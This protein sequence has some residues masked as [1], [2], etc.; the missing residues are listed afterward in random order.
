MAHESPA[1]VPKVLVLNYEYPPLGGG[2]ANATAE[3]LRRLS[4]RLDAACS[5]V[6]SS[7][8]EARVESL[9]AS[10]C[11]HFL[12]IHKDENLH[13]QSNRELLTYSWKA[14]WYARRLSRRER[15]DVAHA[16]FGIPCGFIAMLLGVPYIVS[17]RGSDVPGYS[18]RYALADRLIFRRLSR[19]VW[20]R[21]AAV[22]ANSRGLRELA[23]RT[24]KHQPISVIP[25]GVDTTVFRPAGAG[26][27]DEADT[28]RLLYV[29]RLI[30]R[31]GV[32]GLLRALGG[33]GNVA[34]TVAGDGPERERLGR[35]AGEYGVSVRFPGNVAHAELP[36]LY[37]EHDAFVLPSR[38]EGMSN[39]VLEAMASGLP[40][41]VT[42]VGGTAELVDGN[43]VVVPVDDEAALREAVVGLRDDR[44][45]RREMGERSREIA[46]EY[47]WEKV[48]EEY[49][50]LYREVATCG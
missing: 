20:R 16:F 8:G 3:I 28:L 29:G 10:T 13:Y 24:A 33:L 48:A 18:S 5:L 23:W 22:V 50:R 42:D 27:R 21:A 47:S 34:L 6:T 12:D 1:S 25:N 45:R 17:L 4:K 30:P 19:L 43:G 38:N 37:R 41:I 11:L 26:E 14:L 40:V 7:T 35:M 31:K 36:E 32:A 15:F 9:A 2:A 39:T 49:L 46:L 44:E